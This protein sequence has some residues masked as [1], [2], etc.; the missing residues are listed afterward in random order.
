MIVFMNRQKI[1]AS[2]MQLT[3][4]QIGK[5]DASKYFY[6]YLSTLTRSVWMARNAFAFA[7]AFGLKAKAILSY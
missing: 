5:T 6:F 7:F 3:G 1:S 2:M 4:M